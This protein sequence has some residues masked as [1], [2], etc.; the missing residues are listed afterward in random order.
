[1]QNLV[2][3]THNPDKLKEMQILLAY[4]PFQLVG[5]GD[6]AHL[7]P[8]EEDQPTIL[9]NAAKKALQIAQAT[10]ML[11]LADDTGLFIDCLSGLPGVHS[12]RWAGEHCSY[13]DNRLK[14]LEMLQN[15]DRRSASF[16]T[17]IALAS[18]Q[19][20]IAFKEGRVDGEITRQELGTNGF[21]YDSIFLVNAT[22]KT[23]AQMSDEDKNQLSHRALAIAAIRPIL[24]KLGNME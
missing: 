5:M 15:C 12:A 9:G 6:F 10:R 4:L 2:I 3:A 7:P 20:I 13:L 16:R 17:V 19:G 21:G 8:V 22:G 18:P 1:V 14:A 11:C 23:F 24:F